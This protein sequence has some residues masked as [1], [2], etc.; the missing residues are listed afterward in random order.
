M[1]L[2]REFILSCR[3]ADCHLDVNTR[4]L[5]RSFGLTKYDYRQLGR[6]DR[7]RRSCRAGRRV[8]LRAGRVTLN[9]T[10]S[11]SPGKIPIV[12]TRRF[13][14]DETLRG[15]LYHGK[16]DERS[17]TLHHISRRLSSPVKV[18]VFNSRSVASRGKSHCISAWISEEKFT[19]VG[20]VETWHDGPDC[21]ALV[22]CAPPGYVYTERSRPRTE[23]QVC[24]TSTNH[25]GVCLLYRDCLHARVINIQQYESFEHVAV[26][27]HGSG[28]KSLFIVIYRPGSSPPSSKFLD[29][30]TDLLDHTERYS[31]II[32]MGDIN[33][34]LDAST[35]TIATQFSSL[36][37]AHNLVQVVQSPTHTAGHTLDVVIVRS[38]LQVAAINV[39]PPVLSDHSMIEVE[40][41]LR[42]I[43]HYSSTYCMKRPWRTFD[44]AAF[45]RDL[46]QSSLVCSTPTDVNELFSAYNDTLAS[47]LDA[48]APLH[49]V[50]RSTR[51]SELWYDSECRATKR[52]TRKLERKYRRDKSAES[53]MEWRKQ[54][55]VQ[56]Q[57]FHQK[58]TSYWSGVIAGCSNDAKTMWSK[59]QK[60][61]N[62]PATTNCQHSASDI[63]AHFVNKV[64]K[65]RASTAAVDQLTIINRPSDAFASFELVTDD[66]A[67]KLL[68][69][70]PSKHCAL[71]PAPTWLV[72]R[73][74]GV[75][76]PV[77]AAI[78]NASLQ[79]GTLPAHQK[80][81]L[82]NA[83][84]K[85][86]S[87][88]PDDLNSFRPI[89]NLSFISKLV[90]RAVANQFVFHCDANGL[91]PAR[92]SAYRRLHSTESAVLV[93]YNDIVRAV[94][95][96]HVVAMALLDLSSAF[97]TVD[98][99]TLLSLLRQ[100][101]GFAVTGQALM[102]FQSYLTDRNQIFVSDFSQSPPFTLS[103]GVPQGS[104]LGPAQFIAYTDDTTEIFPNYCIQYH[105][106]AD[107]AQA[108]D[109]CPV[110]NVP[111]LINRLSA[112]LKDLA[113][114][115]ASHRLQL[116]P[117]KSEFIWFGSR[118]AL[119]KIPEEYHTLTVCSSAI[120]CSTT[121]R[122]LGVYFDSELQMKAHVS[123]ITSSCYYH[124]RRLFQLRNL[125]SQ[126]VMAQLVTSLIISRLDYCNSVLINLPA[127]TIAP[128]QRVQNTAARLVLGLDRRSS[129]TA[130]L[131]KLHWL[132][133][134]YRILFKVATLMYDVFHYHC[135]AYLRN[136]VTF[137][138]SDSAR[139]RLRSS[140]TRSAVTVRTRTKFGSRAFSVSG[141]TVWN[142]L[143]SQLRLIDCRS[144][145][146][147]R[148]KS[149]YFQL[150]FN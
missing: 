117:S 78:C 109:H 148:L 4:Q 137:T 57:L 122:D 28:L 42:C 142:S 76:S 25:G 49:R 144:T 40:F 8:Q 91:L 120:K 17:T 149:H 92:Q 106:F 20:L 34:H 61:G 132:P 135:P 110:S 133:V 140:T 53:R 131:R 129:I 95:Q 1:C 26:F 71:D 146:R 60:L 66:E 101:F 5:I 83:R 24:S 29:E 113:V 124:L 94:D 126:K 2:S 141:P 45:E 87:L 84:L 43:Q 123:K 99:A 38:E 79:S 3:S 119:S 56:R 134:H 112:C 74:A 14:D 37:S 65:I 48:H 80:Q 30:F 47:L 111:D 16:R 75:L 147:R 102:W 86:Q 82:V 54:F 55:A 97:D 93:V 33:V 21:P 68:M 150:A 19:A 50:R 32:I 13:C 69:R 67:F 63:A 104:C 103:S 81:A 138:E 77:I 145:F 62:P 89:S 108:Y 85:K 88:N 59:I 36:L 143:P 12:S 107:D 90:E 52:T 41:E 139:S 118:S 51:P 116:N 73:A 100:R 125:V 128:L 22:A 7:P 18:G 39:H 96:G 114:S 11:D 46:E 136:L 72:K 15:V 70:S 6:A 58:A 23:S 9:E 127:S 35:D 121:V 27:L 64:D 105:L 10:E 98:H 31:N 115:Y 44:Y 130:A